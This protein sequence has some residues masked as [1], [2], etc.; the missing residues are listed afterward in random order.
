MTMTLGDSTNRISDEERV[1]LRCDFCGP[2]RLIFEPP[3]RQLVSPLDLFRS[4]LVLTT[5]T[6]LYIIFSACVGSS[7]SRRRRKHG[8]RGRRRTR[9]RGATWAFQSTIRD[10]TDSCESEELSLKSG[11]VTTFHFCRCLL[12]KYLTN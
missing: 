12:I 1:S 6:L 3:V 9:A 8:K 4:Q 7:D 5:R 11:Y 10:S 2:K